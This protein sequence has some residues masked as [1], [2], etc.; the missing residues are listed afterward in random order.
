MKESG[1]NISKPEISSITPSIVSIY[2]K[3]HA[4]LTGHNLSD[5]IRV[6]IQVDMDCTP[7][8]SPVWNNTG[9]NL[10]FHIPS[11]DRKGV[12]KVCVVLPDGSCHGNTEITYR[13]SP[14]CTA[15]TPSSSWM[16]GNR[17]ITLMGSHLEFVEGVIHSHTMQDV[18]LPRNSNSQ[19]LIYDTPAAENT[20][21][22]FTSNVFLKTA[23]ETLTCSISIAYHPD[24]EFISFTSTRM[25]NGVHMINI[26]KMADK[27]E[28]TPAE[29]TVWGVQDEKHYLCNMEAKSIHNEIDVFICEIQSTSDTEFQH[30]LIKYGDKTVGLG[31]PSLLHQVL[32]TLRI[33]MI[34]FV[35][36]ALVII[37][38]WQK[39]LAAEMNKF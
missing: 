9:V 19:N 23:N 18:R 16:S 35:T 37:C 1:K 39:K 11:V 28:I 13:S 8:E 34:P 10:T 5:V 25:R 32:L 14:S 36:I 2:G 31:P 12:V 38:W 22:T 3:N 17:K 20:K 6:R 24:P 27:L 15:V 29:L 21:G 33:L 30:L 7:R 26:K 4:L